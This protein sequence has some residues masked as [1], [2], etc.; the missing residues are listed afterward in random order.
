MQLRSVARFLILQ[1][2]WVG[3]HGEFKR[4]AKGTAEPSL[5]PSQLL[6]G[7]QF[8]GLGLPFRAH[9]LER[10]LGFLVGL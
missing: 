5:R 1:S 9:Q 10:A 7:R 4:A 8:L 2:L 3:V 6:L